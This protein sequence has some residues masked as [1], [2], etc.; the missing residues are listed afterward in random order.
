MEG[1]KRENKLYECIFSTGLLSFLHWTGQTM[2]MSR[3]MRNTQ[4]AMVGRQTASAVHKLDPLFPSAWP[5]GPRSGQSTS[6]RCPTSQV[7]TRAHALHVLSHSLGCSAVPGNPTPQLQ[8]L[9][10]RVAPQSF[11][12]STYMVKHSLPPACL[13][14][15]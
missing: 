8:S 10:F 15:S 2:M 3:D 6:W 14:P 1:N 4:S 7:S 11:C 5:L 12:S 9:P 13:C